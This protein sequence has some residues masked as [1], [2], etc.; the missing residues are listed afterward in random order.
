[1]DENIC[2]LK[3]INWTRVSDWSKRSDNRR[4]SWW[5]G[6]YAFKLR[7]V[8]YAAVVTTQRS[9][10]SIF[11][12]GSL[13]PKVYRSMEANPIECRLTLQP[14]YFHYCWTNY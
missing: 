6:C 5:F 10:V 7:F 3:E 12:V 13:G 2:H 4:K 14:P 1:M 9:C 8:K 11:G